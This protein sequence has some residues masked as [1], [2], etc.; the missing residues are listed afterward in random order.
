MRSGQAMV[1][2]PN[3]PDAMPYNV[4]PAH[5]LHSEAQ[6]ITT[7]PRGAPGLHPD[8]ATVTEPTPPVRNAIQRENGAR[9]APARPARPPPVAAAATPEAAGTPIG[10]YDMLISARALRSGATLVTANVKEFSRVR[11]LAWQDWSA[12]AWPP[13]GIVRLN[14]QKLTAAG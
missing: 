11:D 10:R 1:A 9:P 7:L 5:A 3:L 8:Q 4:G 13:G 14:H 12:A 6:R 2:Q